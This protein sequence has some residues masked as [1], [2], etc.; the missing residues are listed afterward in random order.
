MLELD[1][2]FVL[3]HRDNLPPDWRYRWANILCV[4][5]SFV[6]RVR[7]LQLVPEFALSADVFVRSVFVQRRLQAHQ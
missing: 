4:T 3:L 2:Q 1:G 7:R 5:S 6:H